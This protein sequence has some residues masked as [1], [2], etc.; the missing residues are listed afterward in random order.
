MTST[1]IGDATAGHHHSASSGALTSSPA[2]PTALSILA[3]PWTLQSLNIQP[4]SQ[5][6]RVIYNTVVIILVMIQE[7]FYLGT[8]NGLYAQCKL[9]ARSGPYRIILL[10]N[11]NS[12]A[13]TFI[14]RRA[15]IGRTGR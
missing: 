1:S 4:T 12:L 8:I 2:A 14:G 3:N 6:S 11:L 5:G 9:Y 7:F 13:Y 10:R 15:C